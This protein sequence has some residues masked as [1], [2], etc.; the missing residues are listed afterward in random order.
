MS[1]IEKH[2]EMTDVR[3]GRHRAQRHTRSE[4]RSLSRRRSAEETADQ[5]VGAERR[6]RRG[7]RGGRRRP[8]AAD[9]RDNSIGNDGRWKGTFPGEK[10]AS[11]CLLQPKGLSRGMAT[12]QSLGWMQSFANLVHSVRFFRHCIGSKPAICSC[13]Y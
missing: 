8:P 9:R 1:I 5:L 4:L 7:E 6:G 2:G 11:H 3:C 12:S 10:K 13:P